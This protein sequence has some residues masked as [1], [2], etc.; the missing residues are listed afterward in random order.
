METD[1]GGQNYVNYCKSTAIEDAGV[2]KSFNND[3]VKGLNLFQFCFNI[4]II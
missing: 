3:V 4:Y 2:L 1:V